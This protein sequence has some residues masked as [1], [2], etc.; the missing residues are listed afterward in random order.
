MSH[1]SP[2][3]LV[4]PYYKGQHS[5][6]EDEKLAEELFFGT[7]VRDKKT[8]RDCHQYP[9]ERSPY[10]RQGVEALCRLL[11]FGC[12]DLKPE[13]LGGLLASLDPSGSF[14]RRLVFKSRKRKRP[15]DSRT[16]LQIFFQVKSLERAGWPTEAAVAQVMKKF[17]ISRETVYRARKR[18]RRASPWLESPWVEI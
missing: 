2:Y 16:D 3:P 14:E 4:R 17:G 10:E 9:P 13:I 11:S 7:T 5:R 18:I 6:E 8:G 12:E 1:N 15:A